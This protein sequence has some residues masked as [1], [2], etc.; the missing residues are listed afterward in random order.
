MASLLPKNTPV[1]RIFDTLTQPR[2]QLKKR[3]PLD[4]DAET[5]S[6][7]IE[8]ASRFDLKTEEL[9]SHWLAEKAAEYQL[10]V[11][12]EKTWESLTP[13]EQSVVGRFCAGYEEPD[14]APAEDIQQATV[15][16]HLSKAMAKFEVKKRAHL[17]HLLRN[18]DFSNYDR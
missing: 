5:L 15:R 3:F 17:R 10:Q 1:R 11:Q 9:A 12:L 6:S 2:P 7:L 14:I 18:W 4:V 13:K 8:A 16:R